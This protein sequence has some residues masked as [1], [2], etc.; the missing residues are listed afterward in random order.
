MQARPVRARR[1]ASD[2]WAEVDPSSS[3]SGGFGRQPLSSRAMRPPNRVL[4]YWPATM[5]ERD[6]ARY[7]LEQASLR[8]FSYHEHADCRPCFRNDRRAFRFRF[9]IRINAAAAAPTAATVMMGP[10]KV[11]ESVRK[12]YAPKQSFLTIRRIEA[13]RMNAK[14]FRVR[15][16]KSFASLRHLPSHAKVRSTTHRRGMTSKPCA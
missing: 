1:H 8:A 4:E 16:S 13:R 11:S 10:N 2:R 12:V 14:A 5:T 3:P 9:R 15:F 7:R 6:G